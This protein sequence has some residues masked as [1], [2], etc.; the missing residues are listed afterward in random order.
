MFAQPGVDGRALLRVPEVVE[1]RYLGID[2]FGGRRPHP[3]HLLTLAP[4]AV[5]VG[6]TRGGHVG[7]QPTALGAERMDA[8]EQKILSLGR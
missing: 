7:S 5:G 6:E 2:Q 4:H 8:L 1:V 3:L